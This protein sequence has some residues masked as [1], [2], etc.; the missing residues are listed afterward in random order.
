MRWGAEFSWHWLY[1][2]ISQQELEWGAGRYR[3]EKQLLTLLRTRLRTKWDREASSN[4][5]IHASMTAD[6]KPIMT[7]IIFLQNCDWAMKRAK[8][9]TNTGTFKQHYLQYLTQI[10]YKVLTS[11]VET[12]HSSS[13]SRSCCKT[14]SDIDGRTS[15]MHCAS[16]CLAIQSKYVKLQSTNIWIKPVPMIMFCDGW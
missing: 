10:N 14:C 3:T 1:N 13:F 8:V 4:R 15:R 5:L 11:Q 6:V 2:A 16:I 12:P 9:T 7:M